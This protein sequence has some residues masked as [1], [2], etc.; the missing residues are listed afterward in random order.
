M[1]KTSISLGLLALLFASTTLFFW[2]E[3]SVNEDNAS[4]STLAVREA[5][6]KALGTE[7]TLLSVRNDL[8]L[9]RKEVAAAKAEMEKTKADTNATL[10]QQTTRL[11]QLQAELDRAKADLSTATLDKGKAES[12]AIELEKKLSDTRLQ[13]EALNAELARLGDESE[14]TARDAKIRTLENRIQTLET[15]LAQAH[16]SGDTPEV[17]ALKEDLKK[18]RNETAIERIKVG[19]FEQKAKELEEENE[20]LKRS[21]RRRSTTSVGSPDYRGF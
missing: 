4:T 18:S 5:N 17:L 10:A 14:V 6:Q 15:E 8:D 9:C 21:T 3:S 20:K 19:E 12:G 1:N 16:A 2:S 11:T 13:V 7:K